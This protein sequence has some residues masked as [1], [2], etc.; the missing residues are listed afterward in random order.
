M[1]RK[2]KIN[3]KMAHVAEMIANRDKA[4]DEIKAAHAAQLDKALRDYNA[5]IYAALFDEFPDAGDSEIANS[6][7]KSRN[8][9]YLWR[10]DYRDNYVQGLA[11]PAVS[12]TPAKAASSVHPARKVTWEGMDRLVFP[13]DQGDLHLITYEAIGYGDSAEEADEQEIAA[14][15]EGGNVFPEWLTDD[16]IKS[17]AAR[18]DVMVALAPWN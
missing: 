2:K 10:K 18:L 12:S 11:L 7:G 1:A 6:I 3:E 17:E 15:R 9:V 5:S 8:T 4:R 14:R 13:S 16:L